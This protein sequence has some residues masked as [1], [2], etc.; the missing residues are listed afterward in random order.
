MTMLKRSGASAP[1]KP[2]CLLAAALIA[3]CA[4]KASLSMEAA[5]ASRQA[6]G[7]AIE[8][9]TPEATAIAATACTQA[10][11]MAEK[12]KLIT[13]RSETLVKAYCAFLAPELKT[14]AQ[15]SPARLECAKAAQAAAAELIHRA[16]PTVGLC[17]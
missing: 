10:N 13:E 14:Q 3:G 8:T 2:Y 16:L 12:G 7:D 4:P 6:E 11:A 9:K 15:G 1:V 5:I 17:N